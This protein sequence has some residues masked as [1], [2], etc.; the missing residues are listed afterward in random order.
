MF[1]ARE[2]SPWQS[3]ADVTLSPVSPPLARTHP[4]IPRLLLSTLTACTPLACGVES[5]HAGSTVEF[6]GMC[7]AS[8][9]ATVAGQRLIVANDEDNILRLYART[10]GAPLA[11]FDVSDF[12]GKRGAKKPREADIEGAAQIGPLTYWIT[13]HGRNAKAQEK[14]ERQRLFATETVGEGAVVKVRPA[15]QPYDS[16]LDDLLADPRLARFALKAAADLAPKAPGALNIEGLCST[17]EGGLLI[18][19]RNPLFKGRALIVPLLNPAEVIAGKRAKLGEPVTIDLGGRGI[20]S[21]SRDGA[22]HL[23]IAGAAGKES[24]SS[25]LYA[26]NGDATAPRRVRGVSFRGLNPEGALLEIADGSR[27]VLVLSDDGT[28]QIDGQDC[29][30]LTDSSRKRFRGVRLKL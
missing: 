4:M 21:M 11:E 17:P 2:N 30:A 19:F 15:G 20:R 5:R 12:I 9:V 25:Q 26:W 14:S 3:A 1:P 28:L 27:E 18:G 7:D 16:L 13:S 6:T 23:I 29:K 8:A 22:R 10:G 24:V